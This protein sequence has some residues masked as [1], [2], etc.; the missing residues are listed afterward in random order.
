MLADKELLTGQPDPTD[1]K[2]HLA[3]PLVFKPGMSQEDIKRE[4][5]Y[6]VERQIVL[7]KVL[8]GEYVWEDYL[9]ILSDQ[10][11]DAAFYDECAQNLILPQR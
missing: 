10:N 7:G 4:F 2:N 8:S 5:G 9:D 3:V 1:C 6:M 11:Y